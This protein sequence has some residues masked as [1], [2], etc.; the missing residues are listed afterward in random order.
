MSTDMWRTGIDA[1]HEGFDQERIHDV[2]RL[3]SAVADQ[4]RDA[5]QVV[6]VD[7]Y[8][9]SNILESAWPIWRLPMSCGPRSQLVQTVWRMYRP[10]N[11]TA[12]IAAKSPAAEQIAESERLRA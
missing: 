11:V 10:R 2:Y 7:N 1:G 8:L 9:A 4:Y 3:L 12:G 6:A 5:L